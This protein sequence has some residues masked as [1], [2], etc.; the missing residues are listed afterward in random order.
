MAP[1]DEY[2]MEVGGIMPNSVM[3]SRVPR[4]KQD[5]AA[6]DVEEKELASSSSIGRST[7]GSM[8][9]KTR[10]RIAARQKEENNQGA[11][12][13]QKNKITLLGHHEGPEDGRKGRNG[14]ARRKGK[15]RR[16]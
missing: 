2:F 5:Y 6:D 15:R 9:M 10:K 7:S 12:T 14:K 4:P 3:I 11:D 16:T 8:S 1:I 13:G